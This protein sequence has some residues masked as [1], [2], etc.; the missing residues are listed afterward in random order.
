LN[1]NGGVW[2]S[3]V[4]MARIGGTGQ[5]QMQITGG[6]S[7]F[8]AYGAAV[9]VAFSATAS[10][11]SPDSL[12]WGVANFNPGTLV[13]NEY[14][15]NNTLNF[16]N[17]V[18][19]NG[20]QRTITVNA[21]PTFASTMS[22]LLSGTGGSGLTKGGVG[23]LIL[24]NSNTYDGATTVN[25]GIL[26]LGAT[27]D[28]TNTPLGTTASG[29]TVSATGAALDLAGFT[30][31]T[32]EALSITGTGLSSSVGALT[33]SGGA[34]VY[35]GVVTIGTTGASIGGSGDIELSAGLATN[36]NAPTP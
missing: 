2:E 10:I 28:A 16:V 18:D 11:A 24:T 14:T 22:G 12:Q 31:G 13:L 9:N 5:G 15:A 30:L 32:A 6:T 21:A 25:A 4:N 27:G 33:N 17:P 7:G 35:S 34:A 20:S 3:A 29:T 23:T 19:F 36:A 8:S 26:K 1:L